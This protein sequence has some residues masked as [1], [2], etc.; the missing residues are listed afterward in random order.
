MTYIIRA[1]LQHTSSTSF[2][3]Y[4]YGKLRYIDFA[5]AALAISAS[6]IK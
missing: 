6:V 1:N 2:M 3:I 4:I 5:L